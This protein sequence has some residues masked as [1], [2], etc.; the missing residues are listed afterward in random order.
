[1]QAPELMVC[2]I[3]AELSQLTQVRQQLAALLQTL[4][5]NDDDIH[6][7]LLAT[8]EWIINLIKHAKPAPQRITVSLNL[9]EHEKILV[10][11]KDDGAEFSDFEQQYQLAHI[12]TPNNP[13]EQG[14]GLFVIKQVFPDCSYQSKPD[15]DGWNQFSLSK[16]LRAHIAIIEDDTAL[17][18]ILTQYLNP[19]Y[20]VNDFSCSQAFLDYEQLHSIDLVISDIN[21]PDMDGL[22]LRQQLRSDPTTRLIPFICLTASEDTRIEDQASELGIDDYLHKPIT[23]Q[24]LQRVVKRVLTRKQVDA[25]N[26]GNLLNDTITAK[27]RPALPEQLGAYRCAV[28]SRHATGGGGDFIVHLTHDDQHI[29]ILGDVMGHGLDAKFF[30]HSYAGYIQG[31]I[32]SMDKN[33]DPANIM[34]K[35]S[36]LIYQD[37]YL[38]SIIV[39]CIAIVLKPKGEIELV[40]AGHPHPLLL[41]ANSSQLIHVNGPLPGIDTLPHYATYK[42][43]LSQRL[44]LYTDG[45]IETHTDATIREQQQQLLNQTII[46][47]S[48]L[49]IDTAAARIMDHF[50]AL[51][52][53]IPADDATLV[54]LEYSAP[55]SSI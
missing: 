33:L 21:M 20:I 41:T 5:L 11:V 35:L 28:Q 15:A 24:Q 51:S 52:R 36:A 46:D 55:E 10:L 30:A 4:Q 45:L 17:R 22:S 8:S 53:G 19:L 27:L 26:M 14:M 25:S 37:P 16:T 38:E 54:L 13:P 49:P 2:M 42:D 47:S 3:K 34:E 39:T 31:L 6:A 9:L 43:N 1:M 12:T 44:L 50:D 7:F 32:H 48:S 40:N 23:K 29:I 18:H